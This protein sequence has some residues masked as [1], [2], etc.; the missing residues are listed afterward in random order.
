MSV[1]KECIKSAKDSRKAVRRGEDLELKSEKSSK[2]TSAKLL[3]LDSNRLINSVEE[4]INIDLSELSEHEI[5]RRVKAVSDLEKRIDGIATKFSEISVNCQYQ[6]DRNE[7]HELTRRY[8][9][10]IPVK[11]KYF[12]DLRQTYED[13]ELDKEKFFKEGF[14]ELFFLE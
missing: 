11:E 8:D 10:F 3:M 2:S 12:K 13:K 9:A 5:K 14:Y 6:E 7:L 1:M 4:E